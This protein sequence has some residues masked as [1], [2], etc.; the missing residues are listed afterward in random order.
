MILA[1]LGVAWYFVSHQQPKVCPFSGRM[2]HPQTRAL[3]TIG[4]KKYETCCVRCAIIEAQQTG[5]PLRVLEVADFET[6]KLV[7]PKS[8]W[9]VESSD[10]NLCMRMAPAA[11]SPGRE[12]V[13]MRGFDRCSPSALAFRSEEQARAFMAQHGGALKRLDDLER[14]A[15]TTVP[16]VQTP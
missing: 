6:G 16:K 14:E 2:I 3:V 11:E 12:S 9:Y 5:K 15:T 7:A 13:Y 1:G 10:V 4:G 8:A